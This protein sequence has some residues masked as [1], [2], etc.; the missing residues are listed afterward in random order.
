MEAIGQRSCTVLEVT[1]EG[2]VR[3][4]LM[5]DNGLYYTEVKSQLI[6]VFL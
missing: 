6:K 2:L 5:P 4:H 1:S 3:T